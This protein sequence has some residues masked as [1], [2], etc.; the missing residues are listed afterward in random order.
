MQ[1][2]C[3]SRTD[4]DRALPNRATQTVT[5]VRGILGQSEEASARE[6]RKR[7]KQ[8]S[9]KSFYTPN[10]QRLGNQE[11]NAS[12]LYGIEGQEESTILKSC[13]FLTKIPTRRAL[14]LSLLLAARSVCIRPVCASLG[15]RPPPPQRRKKQLKLGSHCKDL[16]LLGSQSG[17]RRRRLAYTVR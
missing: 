10:H 16:S 5:A 8:F 17:C 14:S 15:L 3:S 11:E 2:D 1:K 13:Q 9:L 12:A 4:D 7:T 6:P